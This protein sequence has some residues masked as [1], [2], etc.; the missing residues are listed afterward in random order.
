MRRR[1]EKE[2]RRTVSPLPCR[3][4]QAVTANY[5]GSTAIYGESTETYQ[6]CSRSFAV[7]TLPYQDLFTEFGELSR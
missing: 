5:Q 4:V 2:T 1:G 7:I 3:F 6:E